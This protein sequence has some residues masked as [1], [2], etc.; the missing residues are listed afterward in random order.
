MSAPKYGHYTSASGL[1]GILEE[2]T[3]R[4]TNIKFLNDEQ[5]FQHALNLI[6]EIIP[7]SRITAGASGYQVHEQ[8]ID[9]LRRSLDSLDNFKADS[10]FT[11]SFSEETDLLS[12]WR[13]Y[14]PSN[15]GYCIEFNVENLAKAVSK[16]FPDAHLVRCVYDDDEK[17]KLIRQTLNRYWNIY[18]PLDDKDRRNL[19]EEQT[20]AILLLAAYFKNSSFSEEKE[21]RI[22]VIR[23]FDSEIPLRFREGVYSLVPYI[24][25]PAP[26]EFVAGIRIGPNPNIKLAERG[27][28]TF[29]E[30]CYGYPA[31]LRDFQIEKSK[32]PYRPL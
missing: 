30:K 27:L 6:K 19:L 20:K 24:E 14:C 29:L 15:N 9:E 5:E 17:N 7:T 13:G 26:R 8:F 11:I 22:V 28:E 10:V 2:E 12:Q 21:H 25:V 1:R 3:F 31:F 23:D 16:D 4:A 18:F 32:I